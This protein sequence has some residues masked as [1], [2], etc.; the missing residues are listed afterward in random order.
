[1]KIEK[2]PLDGSDNYEALKALGRFDLIILKEVTHEIPDM[3]TFLKTVKE[4]NFKSKW[5]KVRRFLSYC[6][7][8]KRIV[9]CQAILSGKLHF[10]TA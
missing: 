7:Y 4:H 10:K 9:T 8:C 1:M 6:K 3:V 5:S 2:V